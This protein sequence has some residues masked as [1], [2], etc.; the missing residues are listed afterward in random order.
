M[1]I[2]VPSDILVIKNLIVMRIEQD[3]F[4]FRFYH[5]VIK[6]AEGLEAVVNDKS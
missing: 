6:G 3:I 2:P 1:L 5:I 4:K